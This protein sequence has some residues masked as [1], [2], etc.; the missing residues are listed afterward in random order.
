[1]TGKAAS[2]ATD[3]KNLE[4]ES[5]Q[6]MAKP[7]SKRAIRENMRWWKMKDHNAPEFVNKTDHNGVDV[8]TVVVIS[9]ISTTGTER[10]SPITLPRGP[11]EAA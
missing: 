5:R 8:K 9:L 2:P 11:W 7:K 1:M 3:P 4:N 10:K 6:D